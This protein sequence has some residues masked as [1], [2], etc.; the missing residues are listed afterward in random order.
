MHS[1]S[2]LVKDRL[3]V[4]AGTNGKRGNGEPQPPSP[5]RVSMLKGP[6]SWHIPISI[7]K[8]A[9]LVMGYRQQRVSYEASP[10]T[11]AP[12]LVVNFPMQGTLQDTYKAYSCSNAI[13]L[14][15]KWEREALAQSLRQRIPSLAT[16]WWLSKK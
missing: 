1:T 9:V 3:S 5:Q 12:Q 8:R 7:V 11:L 15:V 10:S 6:R 4:L 2:I 13:A 14:S 16:G